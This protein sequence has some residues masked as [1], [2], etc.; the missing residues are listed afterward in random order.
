MEV[1]VNRMLREFGPCSIEKLAAFMKR[2]T[3]SPNDKI[4][5]TVVSHKS[6]HIEDLTALSEDELI[7][8]KNK[9][10]GALDTKRVLNELEITLAKLSR[11]GFDDMKV[12]EYYL[13][14][15]P[16]VVEIHEEEY[17]D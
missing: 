9:I 10:T 4:A 3:L 15:K 14:S 7:E 2:D 17:D 1:R 16:P 8:L 6:L 13:S 5:I 12:G 11:L